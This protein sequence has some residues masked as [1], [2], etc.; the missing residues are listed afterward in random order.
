M[1]DLK[2]TTDLIV[3]VAVALLAAC[4]VTLTAGN[5]RHDFFPSAEQLTEAVDT[6]PSWVQYAAAGN[7][8]GD[9]SAP[10]TVTI[11]SDYQCPACRELFSKVE[12]IRQTYPRDVAF[13]WRDLPLA[14]HPF[15]AEAALGAKCA[16]R[17]GRFE[18]FHILLFVKQDSLGAIP[19]SDLAIRAGIADTAAFRACTQGDDIKEE[20]R[21]DMAA[22]TALHA[23]VTPTVLVNQLQYTGMPNDLSKIIRLV[24]RQVT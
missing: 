11:F 24:R 17:I 15:A 6:V 14:N 22:A 9:S 8:L 21:R 3:T 19:W 2:R 23:V 5:V 10:V 1:A 16:G 12:V 7:R 4:A 20:L 18:A 13:V